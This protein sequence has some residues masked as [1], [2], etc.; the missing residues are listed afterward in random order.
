MK[1]GNQRHS[2]WEN[3][4]DLPDYEEDIDFDDL[5]EPGACGTGSTVVKMSKQTETLLKSQ[6]SSRLDKATRLKTRNSFTLPKVAT[7]KT[8][9]LGSYIKNKVSKP[10]GST[11]SELA[12][13]QSFVL[14]AVAPLTF[15]L[16]ADA[17][18]N[19][20]DHKQSVNP[21]TA[22]LTLIGNSSVQIS[23]LRRSK[24]VSNM[25]RALLLLVEKDSNFTQ[26]PPSLFAQNQMLY[27][28]R[29][30]AIL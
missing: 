14:D 19:N 30:P 18:G 15:F 8:P 28:L 21:A 20:V 26:A 22:A 24:L 25:N 9:K 5:S 3:I 27:C 29:I 16:E 2:N 6:F 17:R 12:K 23:H 10:A 7:T 13:I 11:D 1:S 4:P